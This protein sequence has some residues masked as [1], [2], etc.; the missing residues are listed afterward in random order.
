MAKTK[1][2][3]AD[4]VMAPTAASPTPPPPPMRQGLVRRFWLRWHFVFHTWFIMAVRWLA[5]AAARRSFGVPSTRNR[6][7]VIVGDDVAYG[8]GDWVVVGGDFGFLQH[9][10]RWPLRG[11]FLRW[12]AFN[13]AVR[14]STTTD[15]MPKTN[16]FLDAFDVDAG[17]H[18][19][20]DV[21]LVMLGLLDRVPAA[22]TAKN[23]ETICRALE[24]RG[25]VVLVATVPIP[26]AAERTAGAVDRLKKRSDMIREML[27]RGWPD[28][29]DRVRLGADLTVPRQHYDFCFDGRY[30]SALGYKHCARLWAEPLLMACK[31]VEAPVY[32]TLQR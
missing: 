12:T 11:L 23:L 15:W 19:D 5:N 28:A 9:L 14:G 26:A 24:E 1:Q 30:F 10:P 3:N 16:R 7:V 22:V 31:V 13:A 17:A 4:S 8:V 21:V 25:K 29:T 2:K 27:Q 20:A 18:A 32:K 6:K